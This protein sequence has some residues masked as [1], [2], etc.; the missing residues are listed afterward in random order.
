MKNK[1]QAFVI[2]V[3]LS[4]VFSS[5]YKETFV[6][7]GTGLS[8]W[9]SASHS[10][11]A[12]PDYDVVFD[13]TKVNRVDL[14]I[15]ARYWAILSSNIN[16]IYGSGT[17]GGGRP[18]GGPGGGGGFSE[19]TPI[20]VPCSWFFNG[21][22]WYNVGIRYKGNSSLSSG[23][24]SGNGKLPFR[25]KFDYYE[26]EFPEITGQ[27]FYGFTDLS[28]SSNYDDPSFMREKVATDLFREFGVPAPQTAYYQLYIDYGEGPVYF[29]LYTFVEVVFDTMLEKQF[30]NNTGNCYKPDGNGAAWSTSN[31][32]LADFEKKTNETNSDWSDIQAVY[33]A[34]HAPSRTADTSLYKANLEAVFDVDLFL[35]YLAVNTTIQNW[36]TY[37]RMTHNYYLYN[38]PSTNLISWI[39]WDN[40]EAFQDG[41]MGGSLSFE[42]DDVVEKD[43][44]LIAYIAN[45]PSYRAQY[46]AYI[47]DFINTTFEPNKMQTQY[48]G[49]KTIIQAS[50]NKEVSGYTYLKGANDFDNA[51]TE[52]INHTSTRYTAADLYLN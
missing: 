13:Q 30:G 20:Y 17:S 31:F 15:D 41:K 34:L 25:V 26:D 6:A 7:A 39:P 32:S 35:K 8:D 21:K 19:E 33:D 1:F 4:I 45:I 42:L 51:V 12:I 40:N 22:E 48:N 9:S 18:A 47:Q 23:Y 3:G 29:G 52:I 49:L 14:V 50:V 10:A 2:I 36:D 46:N 37:G 44:P 11:L 38:N 24:Q 28:L 43:W 27:T 16:D 5:C